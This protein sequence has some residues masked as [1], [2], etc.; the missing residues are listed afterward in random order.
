MSPPSNDVSRLDG[1]RVWVDIENPPQ[2]RYLVPLVQTFIARGADVY[3]T[4]RDYGITFE[5]LQEQ[6]VEYVSVGR[7]FGAAKSSKIAGT[8]RRVRDLRRLLARNGRP[9]LVLSASR[10]AS[11]AAWSLRLPSFAHCD[12]EHADFS[13]FRFARSYLLHPA[14]IADEVFEARGLSRSRLLSYRGIKEDI[15]FAHIDLESIEPY[16]LP[17]LPGPDVSRLLYRPPAEESHYHRPESSAL[18]HSA[19]RRLAGVEDVQVILSPR[20]DW[21]ADILKE[22]DWKVPPFVLRE[23]AP[24]VALLKSVNVVASG[25]GTMTREAAYLGIPAVSLFRGHEGLVDRYLESL[26]R[27]VIVRSDADLEKLDFRRLAPLPPLYTNRKAA[28]DVV[29]AILKTIGRPSGGATGAD[30]AP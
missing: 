27:L 6:G 8:L 4:A 20:Y 21:Q 23:A 12:Y 18:G 25:G 15:T 9:D 11:L 22:F 3:V 1:V 16:P 29:D 30:A 26:G 5:L 17:E 19:L 13:A 10:S 24:F 7:H 14:V 2:V 28:D